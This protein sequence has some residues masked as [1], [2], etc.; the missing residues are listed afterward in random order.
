MKREN[1]LRRYVKDIKYRFEERD[2]KTL[3][4]V[5]EGIIGVMVQKSPVIF[6]MRR[7]I[8]KRFRNIAS[9]YW[10][11]SAQAVSYTHLDVYK[12]QI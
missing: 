10:L 1:C 12:R 7:E 9:Y 11:S 3:E 8:S 5:I 4:W 6:Y 2:V